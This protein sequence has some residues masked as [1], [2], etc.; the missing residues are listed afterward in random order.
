MWDES[1]GSVLFV[2][3]SLQ[4]HG[5]IIRLAH[6]HRRDVVVTSQGPT[7]S[8]R[9]LFTAGCTSE[10]WL[11]WALEAGIVEEFI[12]SS[13]YEPERAASLWCVCLYVEELTQPDM[14]PTSV[15]MLNVCKS[16]FVPSP[17]L[18]GL[19]TPTRHMESAS[20]FRKEVVHYKSASSDACAGSV[21][22]MFVDRKFVDLLT[23]PLCW[24]KGI[25]IFCTAV[26]NSSP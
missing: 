8:S 15:Q 18:L 16:F 20:I 2:R 7:W 17:L 6:P 3:S 5:C 11:Q 26:K 22:F 19:F 23:F 14:T 10:L 24:M 12:T 13:F 9:S 4:P 1:Y 21:S 25:F